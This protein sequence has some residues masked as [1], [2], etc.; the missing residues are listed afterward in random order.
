ML[1]KV[2]QVDPASPEATQAKAVLEQLK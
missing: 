1:E 2:I